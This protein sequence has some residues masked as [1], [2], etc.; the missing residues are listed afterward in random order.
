M[1]TKQ[2]FKCLMYSVVLV[3]AFMFQIFHLDYHN[4]FKSQLL[5][6][7]A[8]KADLI[9]LCDKRIIPSEVYGWYH[10]LPESVSVRDCIVEATA[11]IKRELNLFIFST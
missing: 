2:S 3:H 4:C 5:I 1:I 11:I 6:S 9:K 7:R 10:S 8:K